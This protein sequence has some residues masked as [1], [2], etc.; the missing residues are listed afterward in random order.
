MLRAMPIDDA[1]RDQIQSLI[2]GN[3]VMLFMKGHREAPQCGFSARVVQMLDQCIPDYTTFDVLSSGTLREGIKEFSSWPT[4]PQLYVKGE[5]V[6]GCDIITELFETGELLDTFGIAPGDVE[7][8]NIE[9]SNAA[10]QSIRESLQGMPNDQALHLGIDARYQAKLFVTPPA[11]N[12]IQVEVLNI[13][14]HLDPLSAQRAE[15][16]SID[17]V[18]TDQGVGFRVHLPNAP[19]LS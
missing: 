18:K 13:V 19:D 4:I 1:T 5:F 10:A 16:A 8:P 11:S 15:G 14:M 2:S 7:P 6:G 12:S 9:I 17:L 3:Q